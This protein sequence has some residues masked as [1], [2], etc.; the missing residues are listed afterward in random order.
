MAFTLLPGFLKERNNM[1]INIIAQKIDAVEEV[2]MELEYETEKR[3]KAA[4]WLANI[5][6]DINSFLKEYGYEG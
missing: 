5:R 3:D 2:M 4:K 1:D 6:D